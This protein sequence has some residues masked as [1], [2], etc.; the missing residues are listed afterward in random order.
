MSP[1]ISFISTDKAAKP[2]GHYSQAVVYKD[3]I[4]LSAQLGIVPNQHPIQVGSVEEQVDQVLKNVRE[5]LIAAGSNLNR[6]LKVTIYLSDITL[7]DKINSIYT[8]FFAQ[9]KPARAV[10]PVKELHHGFQ[11]A[12]DVIA[13]VSE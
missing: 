9:H 13:A 5:I 11:V 12:M 6:V 1:D 3:T 8:T 10:I 2:L 7:W 4:Y